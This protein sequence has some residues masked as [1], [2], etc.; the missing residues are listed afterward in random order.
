MDGTE[1]QSDEAKT[2]VLSRNSPL[3]NSGCIDTPVSRTRHHKLALR[4]SLNMSFRST[5]SSHLSLGQ[6]K[7]TSLRRS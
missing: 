7:M 6:H 4:L 2:T 3:L 1:W 5:R